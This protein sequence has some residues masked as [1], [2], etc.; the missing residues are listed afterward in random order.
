MRPLD[1]QE[2]DTADTRRL[3]D[4]NQE[5]ARSSWSDPVRGRFDEHYARSLTSELAVLAN[6]LKQANDAFQA[7]LGSL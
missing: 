6:D 4:E 2:R 3:W 5:A 7:I 1:N